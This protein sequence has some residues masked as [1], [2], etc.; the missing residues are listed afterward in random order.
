MTSV[1]ARLRSSPAL[2]VAVAELRVLRWRLAGRTGLPPQRAKVSVLRSLARAHGLRVLVESGTYQGDT[3]AALRRV[4]DRVVSIELDPTLARAA[5]DRFIGDPAIEII[6]GD[7]AAVIPGVLS[8][9]REPALFWLDGHW[10]GGSTA[11]GPKD[12]PIAEELRAVLGH[13][14]AGHVVLIDDARCF[15]GAN[16]AHRVVG[17]DYPTFAEVQAMVDELRPDS[18]VTVAHDI[19]RIEPAGQTGR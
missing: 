5:R 2:R 15:A 8:R 12:T 9:L 6:E 4:V 7:G 10:S 16:D 13:E 18:R 17:V 19:I 11:R 1:R 3:V 14:V